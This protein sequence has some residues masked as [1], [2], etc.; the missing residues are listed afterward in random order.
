MNDYRFVMLD[1]LDQI[2]LSGSIILRPMYF[3]IDSLQYNNIKYTPLMGN[4]NL[5]GWIGERV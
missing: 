3:S 4:Y 5:I 1:M 2:A